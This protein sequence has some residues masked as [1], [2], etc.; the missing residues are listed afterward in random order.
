[1]NEN[2]ETNLYQVGTNRYY[3][4]SNCIKAYPA[5][6]RNTEDNIC[7][8]PE[9]V[10]NTEY[11]NIH[12]A[13]GVKN[14]LDV[15]E[16]YISE[17][18]GTENMMYSF[19]C[20]IEGYSFEVYGLTLSKDINNLYL[21]IRT[22]SQAVGDTDLDI[23]RVLAPYID[24]DL[25]APECLDKPFKY[26]NDKSC[27]VEDGEAADAEYLFRGL[28]FSTEPIDTTAANATYLNNYFYTIQV[29]KDGEWNNTLVWPNVKAGDAN[30]YTSV[31]LGDTN[32]TLIAPNDGM[33]AAGR[34]NSYTQ[35]SATG[36]STIFAVGSGD[37]DSVRRNA[38]E[39]Y[40]HA[41]KD[42]E[43]DPDIPFE[44]GIKSG[45]FKVT[46]NGDLE[47]EQLNA[48]VSGV[49]TLNDGI[50]LAPTG[51]HII[52]NKN[53]NKGSNIGIHSY[54]H[55]NV[56]GSHIYFKDTDAAKETP[57]TIADFYVDNLINGSTVVDRGLFM[58]GIGDINQGAFVFRPGAVENSFTLKSINNESI[59]LDARC[60]EIVI[61]N[62]NNL[63]I[64]NA[65]LRNIKEIKNLDTGFIVNDQ[66]RFKDDSIEFT[67]Y[68][69]F[70]E[71]LGDG[72]I[73]NRC[74]LHREQDGIGQIL[75]F[76]DAN[77]TRGNRGAHI[78]GVAGIFRT[79]AAAK[80]T[81][82]SF[83]GAGIK[84]SSDGTT[85]VIGDLDVTGTVTFG[86]MAVGGTDNTL[87]TTIIDNLYPVGSIYLTMNAALPPAFYADNMEWELV[88]KG[89]TLVGVDSAQGEFAIAGK[90]GG[91]YKTSLV[92]HS[93][94][95]KEVKTEEGDAV[96]LTSLAKWSE[97]LLNNNTNTPGKTWFLFTE[98]TSKLDRRWPCK[99][100]TSDGKVVWKTIDAQDDDAGNYKISDTI[101]R[102]L[103]QDINGVKD[104]PSIETP[105]LRTDV[106]T[107]NHSHNGYTNTTRVPHAHPII[108]SDAG[109]DGYTGLQLNAGD[110][111]MLRH[112][113]AGDGRQGKLSNSSNRSDMH[114]TDWFVCG[115]DQDRSLEYVHQN[116][117]G[118]K[119]Q[120]DEFHDITKGTNTLHQHAIQQNDI[121]HR[122]N[123][124]PHQHTLTVDFS[125]KET[126]PYG[127]LAPADNNYNN[128]PPY[129]TCYIWRRKK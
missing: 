97:Q 80:S 66:L 30:N 53:L 14:L 63:T 113:G 78:G 60:S 85:K 8:N 5:S 76:A 88:S 42:N 104:G 82:E 9:S 125:S 91:Q 6:W 25:S 18:S 116:A 119:T 57:R 129:F 99:H 102:C 45:P 1:M 83:D 32:N 74:T 51:S 10:L 111:P 92:N 109:T 65:E 29:L 28:V 2:L 105:C 95:L 112:W 121:P 40:G 68:L 75:E 106:G 110:P 44:T 101:T 86:K 108:S 72:K 126:D 37:S 71:I 20:F 31:L 55:V 13:G 64:K 56:I 41:T 49:Y 81:N 117:D 84:L 48:K 38:F 61:K 69:K 77:T 103:E 7:F 59:T 19:K 94:G 12:V 11:N 36:E 58:T 43:I 93:H 54:G 23:T 98:H 120:D 46:Y 89:R 62:Q 96:T 128:M 70:N 115:S 123:L 15:K 4:K 107:A 21:G 73:I 16:C 100:T 39:V 79:Q 27:Y 87:I 47:A 33:V 26:D 35:A 22:I 127:D 17:V 34:Y 124:P 50:E 122:H 67:D 114:C 24:P 3:V 52:I 90:T 118:Y